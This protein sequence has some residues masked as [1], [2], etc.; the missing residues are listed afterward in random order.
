MIVVASATLGVAPA[1]LAMA[2]PASPGSYGTAS[3][4]AQCGT[5][6]E[7]GAFNA[8]NDVYGPNSSAFGTSG[9]DGGG[10]TGINNSS[11]CG[12]R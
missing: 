12:A 3:A 2:S 9:G 10:Q 5:S 11:V 7:S 4:N 8:H 1:G 6:A